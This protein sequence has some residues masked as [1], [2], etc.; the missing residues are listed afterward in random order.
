MEEVAG[1][2]EEA[3][4]KVAANK[5]A[6]G[7]DR[8]TIEEGYQVVVDTDLEQFFDRVNHQRLLALK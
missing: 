3:F 7:P 2:L 6:P 1:G 4:G 5:G 8:Q